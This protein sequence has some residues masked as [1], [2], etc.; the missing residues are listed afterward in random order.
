M[1][2]PSLFFISFCWILSQSL[3][4]QNNAEALFPFLNAAGKWGYLNAQQKVII[5]YSFEGASPFFEERA[6]VARKLPNKPEPVY[7][8]I[9]TKGKILFD[10]DF[11]NHEPEILCQMTAYRYY[12]GLLHIPNYSEEKKSEVFYDKQGKTALTINRTTPMGLQFSE[13]LVFIQETDS[14]W[15]F[16]DKQGKTVLQG[17][18][19]M[20]PFEYGFHKGW[21]VMTTS[22]YR[23]TYIDRQGKTAPFMKS[24]TLSD[25]AAMHEGFALISL[26][27]PKD[28]NNDIKKVLSTDG[29]TKLVSLLLEN[30][31]P[32]TTVSGYNFSNG[33][34]LVQ[35]YNKN[36][37]GAVLSGY[38]NTEGKLAFDLPTTLQNKPYADGQ[39][40]YE[41]I[42]GSSFHQGLACWRIEKTDN[43]DKFCKVVYINTQGKI[44]FESAFV[45]VR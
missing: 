6:F 34:V 39:K 23:V 40:E 33:L 26:P 36:I 19:G 21:S 42:I 4:A 22:D 27:N 25:A 41:T 11:I 5:P 9:D 30:S 10:V 28:P 20:G 1:K 43:D 32:V 29:T 3:F 14:T 17:K 18:C 45:K 38:L 7:S 8:V 2:I 13:G 35:Y 16:I 12:E 37:E 44:V 15:L 24:L 31:S